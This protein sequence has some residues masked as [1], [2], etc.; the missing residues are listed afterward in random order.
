[1]S[2]AVDKPVDTSFNT[3]A[4]R[5]YTTAASHGFHEYTPKFGVA[6]Q[7]TRHILSWLML[8]TTELAEAAEAARKNNYENFCEELA[9]VQIRLLDMCYVL[10][11]DLEDAVLKKMAINENRPHKHGGKLA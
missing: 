9:D 6:G 10:D 2:G 4:S 11:V 1:M 8:I 7:D 5:A 3:L